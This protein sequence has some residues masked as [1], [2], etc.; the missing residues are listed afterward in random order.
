MVALRADYFGPKSF[1]TI[2]GIS[3]LIVMMG[4]TLGPLFSGILFDHYGNYD[5]AFTCIAFCSLLGALMFL[6]RQT[7]QASRDAN[8]MPRPALCNTLRLLY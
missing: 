8:L 6:V 2:M 7:A 3:S 5:L 1:G 4:M